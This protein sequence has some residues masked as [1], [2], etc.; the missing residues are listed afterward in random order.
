MILQDPEN[1]VYRHNWAYSSLLQGESTTEAKKVL[2]DLVH[3]YRMAP[4]VCALAL[5]AKEQG[6][7]DQAQALIAPLQWDQLSAL[8]QHVVRHIAGND[9]TPAP[10][11]LAIDLLPE[12]HQI[13]SRATVA[14]LPERDQ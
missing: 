10:K 14:S 9:K 3:A 11:N 6:D 12:E 13:L 7:T 5:F 4:A 2:Q 8:D 1:P